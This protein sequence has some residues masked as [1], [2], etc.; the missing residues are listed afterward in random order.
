MFLSSP[1]THFF[2]KKP[3]VPMHLEL[4]LTSCILSPE[5]TSCLATSSQTPLDAIFPL[6]GAWTDVFSGWPQMKEFKR[7]VFPGMVNLCT[8][9]DTWRDEGKCFECGTKPSIVVSRK[10]NNTYYEHVLVTKHSLP[11]IGVSRKSEAIIS[12]SQVKRSI[13]ASILWLIQAKIKFS[14]EW[15]QSLVGCFALPVKTW[16]RNRGCSILME[17]GGGTGNFCTEHIYGKAHQG[18]LCWDTSAKIAPNHWLLGKIRSQSFFPSI[19]RPLSTIYSFFSVSNL[20]QVY[21]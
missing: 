11:A 15:S 10:V 13:Y 8:V 19:C 18:S 21:H 7:W 5:P 6:L 9:S 17:A 2:Q 14:S 3:F 20:E 4:I 16:Q 1:P 12:I